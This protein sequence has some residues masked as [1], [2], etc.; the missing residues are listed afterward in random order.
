VGARLGFAFTLKQS[1]VS[2][3]WPPNAILL[4][5]LLLTSPREWTAILLA[6]FVAHLAVEVQAG[7]PMAMTLCWFVS[8]VSEAALG[9]SLIRRFGG[10]RVTLG[11][12]HQALVFIVCGGLV[13]PFLTSFLDAWFVALNQWGASPYW[14]VW[15]TR[16]FSNTLATLTVVP[17]IVLVARGLG[18]IRRAPARRLIEAAVHISVLLAVSW[19]IFIVPEGENSPVLTYAVTPVLIAAALRFGPLGTSLSLLTCAL[20][21]I[22]GAADGRGPFVGGEPLDNALSIQLF[23]I[24]M[25][26]SLLLLA[27]VTADRARAEAQARKSEEQF[28]LALKATGVSPWDWDIVKN[29]STGSIVS[30]QQFGYPEPQQDIYERF[31]DLVHPDDR[32][33]IAATVDETIRERRGNIEVE[34]RMPKA[35]GSV[36]WFHGLGTTILDEWGTPRQMVGITVDITGRKQ[37]EMEIQEQRRKVAHLGRVALVGELSVL[38]THELKQPLTAILFNAKAGQRLLAS[39]PAN[40]ARINEILEDIALDDA[41]ATEVIARLRA[42]LRDDHVRQESL[43]VNTLV[44]ESLQIARPHLV[45]RN[46]AWDLRLGSDVPP[47]HADRIQMQQILLNLVINGCEAMDAVPVGARRLRVL[48]AR[49]PDGSAHISISDTGRGITTD[50]LEEVFEPFVT[51]KE[52]GLGLGLSI[53]RSLVHA[54]GGRIWAESAAAGAT[55]HMSFPSSAESA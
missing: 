39:N 36:A 14:I 23:L 11:S 16:F 27:A 37:T 32:Q 18:D 20:A 49:G 1:P 55:F 24:V 44:R 41:R 29:T 6:A 12:F 51:T 52:Q 33:M 10:R 25:Q 28:R 30:W 4:A 21:A 53:C 42:L 17:A 5:S 26:V 47:V 7:V 15:R 38:L 46:V 3:L 8:N 54:H 13:A 35:D 43:D 31:L 45:H 2:I 50:R 40:I 19:W 22:H 48:T 9:V 34:Y